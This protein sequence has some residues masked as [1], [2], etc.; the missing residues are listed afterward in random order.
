MC[1]ASAPWRAPAAVAASKVVAGGDPAL[2]ELAGLIGDPAVRHRGT[3]GG[4]IANN[5]PSADYPAGAA[6]PRRHGG[7][8]PPAASRQEDFF[9]GLFETALQ[10]GEIVTAVDVPGGRAPREVP[11]SPAS[12]Y[13][14]AG[15]FVA[16]GRAVC[17]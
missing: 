15:V 16:R 7:D 8:R 6:R 3:L 17:G 13:A 11:R 14:M 1:C 5:D 9:L 10:P 4:S 12:R 2:A